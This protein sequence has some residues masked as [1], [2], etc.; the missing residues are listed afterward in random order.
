[1]YVYDKMTFSIIREKLGLEN[2]HTQVLP[3]CCV[4]IYIYIHTYIYIYIYLY[5]YIVLLYI[6][7]VVLYYVVEMKVK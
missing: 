3:H 5:I 1:M 4:Y 2:W 6:L 7:L